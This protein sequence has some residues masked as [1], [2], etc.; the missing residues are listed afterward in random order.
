MARKKSSYISNIG[1]SVKFSMKEALEQRNPA[2][3]GFA[4]QNQEFFDN[5]TETLKQLR[6]GQA[7]ISQLFK[8][9]EEDQKMLDMVKE[10]PAKIAQQL[11][12]GDF[13]ISEEDE[14]KA[15]KELIAKIN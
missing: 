1:K 10:T 9:D 3:S 5:I 14:M 15:L 2:I 7:K 13:T 11:K 4:S 8:L 6:S 12:T